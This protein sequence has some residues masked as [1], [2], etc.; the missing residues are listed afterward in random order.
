MVIRVRTAVVSGL[1]TLAPLQPPCRA[2]GPPILP[3][4]FVKI[5]MNLQ[6]ASWAK[7]G[8]EEQRK[9]G[10]PCD[11]LPHLFWREAKSEV[12]AADKHK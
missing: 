8:R 11:R 12:S 3:Q 2:N 4:M 7:S 1:L 6:S 9:G 5:R 10:S